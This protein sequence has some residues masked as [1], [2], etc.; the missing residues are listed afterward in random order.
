MICG[1]EVQKEKAFFVLGYSEKV[2][3]ATGE[4]RTYLPPISIQI[5]IHCRTY[6][7]EGRYRQN[8]RSEHRNWESVERKGSTRNVAYPPKAPW[9]VSVNGC[10]QKREFGAIT[11]KSPVA[12]CSH[13][14]SVQVR[15]IT[16]ADTVIVRFSGE[17]GVK[18]EWTKRIYQKQLLENIKY[19][20]EAQDLKPAKLVRMRGRIYIQTPKAAQTAQA[21]TRVFGI[22][23]L[24]PA[25]QTTAETADITQTALQA[26]EEAIEE[27]TT[28]AVRCHRVGTHP[29]TSQDICRM[30][31]EQILSHL[32]QKNPKVNLTTPQITLTVEIREQEAYVY[33]QTIQASG[34]FPVGTQAKTVCLLSGGI[35]SP[36]ACWLTLKRGSPP[37]PIYI[38]N[39]PYTDE[40]ARQKAIEN[41]QQLSQWSA[42]KIRKMY[43]V[44]NGENIKTIQQ[45][46]PAK[47]TCLL[48]KRLMY[49]IA[50]EIAQKEN[51]LGIV[52]GE[53]V[54][55]QASQT[56]HNLFVIDQAATQMPIHRP[57]L[58]FDKL[59]TEALAKK[60]GTYEISIKKEQGCTAAPSMPSTQARLNM[61]KD[62]EAALNI[63]EM[64]KAALAATVVVDLKRD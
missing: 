4:T 43:I 10:K 23:S 9:G 31:G 2:P 28:F 50:Q 37:T 8:L 45:K 57:L 18:S 38:D 34:G 16:Q 21:L 25:K 63:T 15:I 62:A 48:C 30:L 56:M 33:T 52:T 17:T 49:R 13:I 1:G 6:R 58:G 3:N 53:A 12:A 51:A 27:N 20:L 14:K 54:G 35:D 44:P 32:Q 24:S 39:T 55:E 19:T 59:E 11:V 26:A 36:V 22:S 29:Y 60:I 5:V 46:T 7:G 61:V 47:F 40:H 42:G 64:V 41:A